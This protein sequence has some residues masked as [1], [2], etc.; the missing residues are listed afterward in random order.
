MKQV[1][2]HIVVF[3][4]PYILVGVVCLASGLA[5]SYQQT[6]TNGNFYGIAAVYWVIIQWPVHCLVSEEDFT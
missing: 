6:V 1:I 2:S 5:F 4:L 3:L